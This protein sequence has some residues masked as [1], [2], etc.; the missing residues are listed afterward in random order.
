MIFS[1]PA[2]GAA[3][4]SQPD[5]SQGFFMM[6]RKFAQLVT[7]TGSLILAGCG[8]GGDSAS[9]SV[10]GTAA[11]GAAIPNATVTLLGVNGKT[12]QVQTDTSGNF[13]ANTTSLTPPIALLVSDGTNDYVSVS[14]GKDGVANITPLTTLALAM[15]L[16]TADLDAVLANWSTFAPL[17]DEDAVL[18]AI[19]IINAN[20]AAAYNTASVDETSYNFFTSVFAANGNGFDGLLDAINAVSCT[21]T[22]GVPIVYACNGSTFNLAIDTSAY[23]DFGDLG[24]VVAADS[25]WGLVTT[26]SMYGQSESQTDI[27]D[28]LSVPRT[29]VA[30][31]ELGVLT[32]DA[33]SGGDMSFTINSFALGSQGDGSVGS[34]VLG[35]MKGTVYISGYGSSPFTFRFVWTRIN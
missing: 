15:S 5:S 14:P 4:H 8:G 7:L 28:D 32:V 31:E 20:L 16:N 27:V 17:V 18:D 24:L 19:R 23:L 13:S 34:K 1:Y 35:E 6:I 30:M 21:I 25:T 33:L 9:A 29:Q 12:V 10:T 26:V 11:T 22:D 3:G 2:V